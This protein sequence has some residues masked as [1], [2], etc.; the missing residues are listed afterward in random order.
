MCK[1]HL[2]QGQAHSRHS[3]KVIWKKLLYS[4]N[5]FLIKKICYERIL[6]TYVLGPFKPTFS[7]F[8]LSS[9]SVPEFPTY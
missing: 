4:E 2:K 1:M 3:I 7:P 9:F 6:H 8:Q 5:D